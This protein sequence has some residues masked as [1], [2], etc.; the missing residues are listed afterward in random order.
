MDLWNPLS[1]FIAETSARGADPIVF[2]SLG[3][4]RPGTM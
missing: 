2:I 3:L 4:A 1:T